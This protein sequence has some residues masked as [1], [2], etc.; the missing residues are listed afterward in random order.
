MYYNLNKDWIQSD[1]SGIP[2]LYMT[3][4]RY[5][6]LHNEQIFRTILR[7]VPKG[8]P[9]PHHDAMRE[10][11]LRRG[12]YCRPNLAL[13]WCELFGGNTE[14]VFPFAVAIQAAEDWFLLHDD[15]MDNN[16]LRRG[17]PAA[18]VMYGE[19]IAIN[20]GD[21]MQ[22]VMWNIA[23]NES[24]NLSH[25]TRN[26]LFEKLFDIIRTTE[27]G[28]YRDIELS[29]RKVSDFTLDDYWKSI[30]AKAAYYSVY[31]PMQLGVIAAGGRQED[32]ERVRSYGIPIGKAFQMKDD[33]LDCVSSEDV[34]GK[35]VGTD[36][37]CG[38]KTA[39]LWHF[40]QHANEKERRAVEQIYEK[41]QEANTKQ[42][43]TNV[44][45][46]FQK[47]GSIEFAKTLAETL[48]TEARN[49]LESHLA[50]ITEGTLKDT[51]RDAVAKMV[52]RE[53]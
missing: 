44:L 21:A 27:E 24:R 3:F 12:K 32:I 15:W 23:Y 19:E 5:R 8:D 47:S 1:Y 45:N 42:E 49:E 41:P 26:A 39:I 37:A 7:Y 10:Y 9:I 13:L 50:S 51:A 52:D 20:A 25:D 16:N 43:I 2:Q 53:K 28:Q 38:T 29:K 22:T 36:V 4:E 48:A 18:H 31:G 30:H 46:A 35:T 34:L 6:S 33:I 14:Y 11:T 40:M 17:K